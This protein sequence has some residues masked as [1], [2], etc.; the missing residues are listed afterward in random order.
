VKVKENTGKIT[1][2]RKLGDGKIYIYIFFSNATTC[3]YE[4]S[5]S[6]PPGC[7]GSVTD[8]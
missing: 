1:G 4:I 6:L 3:T 5:W 8:F 7:G 2:G